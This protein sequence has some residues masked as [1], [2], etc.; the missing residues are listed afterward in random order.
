MDEMRLLQQFGD[1]TELPTAERLSPARIRLTTAMTAE[2]SVPMTST[3]PST[4]PRRNR[5]AWR[6][7]LGGVASVGVA[8]SLAAVLVLAPD[9]LGGSTPAAR[10]DATQVLR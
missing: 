1:E 9:R 5:P 7:V 6:L 2:S 4:L 8:A 10:A 3:V